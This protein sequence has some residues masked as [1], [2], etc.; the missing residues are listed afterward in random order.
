[1]KYRSADCINKAEKPKMDSAPWKNVA[2]VNPQILRIEACFPCADAVFKIN[3]PFGPGDITRSS[4][5]KLNAN[6]S[7]TIKFSVDRKP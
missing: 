1:M 7:F 5:I 4:A 6:M 3:T 2:T